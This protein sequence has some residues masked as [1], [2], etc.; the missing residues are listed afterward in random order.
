MC[1]VKRSTQ[2]F[3]YAQKNIGQKDMCH[4]YFQGWL[5][6]FVENMRIKTSNKVELRS[7][8]RYNS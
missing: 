4:F 1:I 6:V 2:Y 7:Y 5:F 8:R 3:S